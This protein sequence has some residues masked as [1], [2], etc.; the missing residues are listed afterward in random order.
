[1]PAKLAKKTTRWEFVEM[2]KLHLE[3]CTAL[4]PRDPST[5][6]VT[7]PGA[8]RCKRAVTNI[9]MWVQCFATYV[10]VMSKVHPAAV[11]ELLAYLIFIL[12]ASHDF[13]GVAWVT[14]DA[15][16]RRQAFLTGNQQWSKVNPS[17]CTDLFLWGGTYS[18]ML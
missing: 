14:Y 10:S 3:F 2:A 18:P 15:V 13:G 11:P 4:N 5:T 7:K 16:F 12:R 8:I 17:L 9:A 6:A 1:M